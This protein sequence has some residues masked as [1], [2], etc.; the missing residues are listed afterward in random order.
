MLLHRLI[1]SIAVVGFAHEAAAGSLDAAYLRGSQVYEAAG[2]TYQVQ[3]AAPA[4]GSS[5]PVNQID[6]SPAYAPP[7]TDVAGT[8]IVKVS[9]R[10]PWSWTGAYAG[11]HSGGTLGVSK[12]D[13][14]F[15]GSIFGDKVRTPG[16]F[17]GG[18]IGFNWQAPGSGLVLGAEADF[19]RMD[20]DGTNTCLAYSGFYVS[21]NCHSAPTGLATLAG[22]LGFATG[23]SGHSLIY[24]KGGAAW[25]QNHVDINVNNLYFG[26]IPQ[27]GPTT[28]NQS[29]WGG[30]VGAGVEQ[31]VTPAFSLKLE[32]QY[33]A[34][35]RATVATGASIVF[36]PLSFPAGS[37]TGMTEQFHLVKLG[38]NY[39]AGVDP[40]AQWGA[41]P[42]GDQLKG[43]PAQAWA[44][45]WQ[46]EGGARYWMS[47]GRFQWDNAA[48]FTSSQVLESR[49]TY[50]GLTARPGELY[51]RVDTPIGIFVKGNAGLGK[52]TNGFMNDEDWGIF[53]FI[54][55]SNTLSPSE[56]GH[57]NYWT[58][59]VGYD[60]LIGPGY[61]MGA[62]IGFN[63]YDQNT[64][65][66]G[67]VQIANALFPCLA[68]GDN[69]IV[70]TQ[71]THWDSWRIG[72]AGETTVFDRMKVGADVA[73]LPSTSFV[74]RDDHL[75]RLT[76]TWFDQEGKG[77]GVQIETILSYLVTDNLNIGVGARYWAMWT[78]DGSFTCTGCG[79]VGSIS[80]P[81]AGKFST[82]RYG[83]FVQAG[84]KFGTVPQRFN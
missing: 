60:F 8:P 39:K 30:A 5:Y 32:Y 63:S 72:F 9:P 20:S 52:V 14:P 50:D 34:F 15:G 56:T 38:L 40:K 6:A 2:P 16:F 31:A 62:F 69:Q 65:T 68:S 53:G 12:F 58:A 80:P 35:P 25:V 59:D 66:F 61:K 33:L 41:E 3:S 19:S 55:Y 51:A 27:P 54:S 48:P 43:L 67:C 42:V 11:F 45:G 47:S 28:L 74:G 84:Y 83:L 70:G 46:I 64:S 24:L 79:G 17:A 71:A 82:E 36:P 4:P 57:L 10:V 26:T 75:L 76:P 49:L 22:R 73:Y 13:D 77:A 18:Q 21:S 44:P 7:S 78:T 37:T 81:D 29:Q 1:W 23:R